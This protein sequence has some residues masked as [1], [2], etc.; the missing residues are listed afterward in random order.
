MDDEAPQSLNTPSSGS[1]S[2]WIALQ[3]LA[4]DT[5]YTLSVTGFSPGKSLSGET[6]KTHF[7]T[8]KEPEG[9]GTVIPPPAE[10][11]E[12]EPIEDVEYFSAISL[13]SHGWHN[14]ASAPA[15]SRQRFASHVAY[16]NYSGSTHWLYDA[17][18]CV[19]GI[20]RE[21]RTFCITP[22]G[23]ES[24]PKSAWEEY[25]DAWVGPG[26]DLKYLDLAIEKT[27]EQLGQPPRYRR[28]VVMMLPDPIKYQIFTD[29]DSPT[30]YWGDNLDF[31]NVEDQISACEWFIDRCREEFDNRN[32]KNLSLL[33]FYVV[34]ES[35]P[36]DP[37]YFVRYNEPYMYDDVY[38]WENKRWEKIIPEVA[39]Y[40]HRGNQKLFWI[41]YHLA[42]GYRVWKQLGFDTVWMQPNYYWD[43]GSVS[44]PFNQTI[45]AMTNYDMGMEMEF[46]YSLVESVMADGRGA[47]DGSGSM[48]YHLED[49]PMLRA[50]VREYMKRY[51]DSGKWEEIPVCVYS[52]TDAWNQL[53]SSSYPED[54]NMFDDLCHFIIDS[55]LRQQQ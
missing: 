3:K 13:I 24:A 49:V 48:V 25:L 10:D 50:R 36:L 17:F 33:G 40:I 37:A 6:V 29:T 44:H 15:W 55:P 42:P 52:G 27:A 30:D 53:A 18:L 5:E 41:P 16:T 14:G 21:G 1:S 11:P 35:L 22:S 20:D 9:Q 47:P 51:K 43:H 32:Y 28:Q 46:E 2:V 31:A 34:S 12:P 26:G 45:E 39:D 19:D 38:N 7:R 23:K 8:I 54:K 4:P